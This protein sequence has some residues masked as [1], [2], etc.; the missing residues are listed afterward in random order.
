MMY[1]AQEFTPKGICFVGAAIAGAAAIGVIGSSIS[2]SNAADASTSAAQTQAAAA[3]RA[4]QAQL[5]MFNRTQGNLVPYMTAGKNAL[6][7]IT[8]ATG[9]NPGG[10]PLT[11]PL[12]K[13][14]QMTQAQL[15]STPGYQF[16]RDQG[17]MAVKNQLA[18][19]GLGGSGA[20]LKGVTNYAEGLASGTF[21]TQFSNYLAQNQQ[22]Y[23]MLS[24]ITTLGQN[25]AANVGTLGQQA[26]T[27][28]NALTTGG[29]A[30]LAGGQIGAANAL[31]AGLSGI[32]GSAS[33]AALL[34][35]MNSGGMF[36]GTNVGNPL[37]NFTGVGASPY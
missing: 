31:S 3:D 19:Q 22:I 4:A 37:L 5:E 16:T 18:A 29:A 36:T 28:A 8:F 14:F 2:S 7:Q 26:Q 20:M 34:Y 10:N 11:A 6:D 33:N 1:T 12:T 9:T 27:Q 13:P 35:A 23:N 24:G 21:Q 17:L 15:E 32:G 25:A 30:A